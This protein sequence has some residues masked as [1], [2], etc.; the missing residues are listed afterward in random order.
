MGRSL[1]TMVVCCF[2][3]SHANAQAPQPARHRWLAP[4]NCPRTGCCP[5]DYCPKSCPLIHPVGRCGC[6]DDYCVKPMPHLTDVSRCGV[7]D[8]YCRKSLPGLL[9][10]PLTQYLKCAPQ[11][12]PAVHR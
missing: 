1:L 9:C 11:C 4:W 3:V 5:D 8:D 10:P 2:C 6:P 12:A 7:C